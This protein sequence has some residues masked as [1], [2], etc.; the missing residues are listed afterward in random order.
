MKGKQ[1]KRILLRL[2]GAGALIVAIA[3]LGE[4]GVRPAHADPGAVLF[5]NPGVCVALTAAAPAPG[6]AI[7]ELGLGYD[8]GLG[9]TQLMGAANELGNNDDRIQSSDFAS[10]ATF[11][12][13]QLHQE[14]GSFH[15]TM[16]RL[17]VIAF[18]RSQGPVT[19]H[20]TSG[21]FE[22][23][24]T[25]IWVC[26]GNSA[27]KNPDTDCSP[28]PI[29]SS[30]NP[31]FR[32]DGVVVAYLSCSLVTCPTRGQFSLT[33]EQDGI[34]FPTTFTVVGEPINVTFF[35]LEKGIQAG[36]P[37]NGTLDASTASKACP[38]SATLPFIQKALGEA[39]K[40]VIVARAVDIDGTAIAG[41]WINWTVD[42]AQHV[43]ARVSFDS[44]GILAQPE[45]P[46]LNLGGFGYGA[47]NILC[48][49]AGAVA[50][51]ITVTAR[52][53]RVIQGL[54]GDPY[55]S[56]GVDP[57]NL[58]S[59][60]LA[61]GNVTFTVNAI[62][63]KMVLTA[64][65]AQIPCDGN[66]TSSV[67]AAL[68]DAAGNPAI[69][70]TAVHFDAQ[71]LGTANPID[72]T[73]NDKGIATSTIAPLAGDVR[74]VPVTVSVKV[75]GVLQPDMTQS[76]MVQC[77]G[78]G[79]PSTA[80]SAPGAPAGGPAPSAPSGGSAAGTSAVQGAVAPNLPR[81]GAAEGSGMSGGL[82]WALIAAAA[83][84]ASVAGVGGVVA[85]RR[86]R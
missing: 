54:Y 55:A 80:P 65:P 60:N 3:G 74:G 32:P 50:G 2:A 23:S 79:A 77:T 30:S 56:H 1:M 86:T 38:F 40:T 10:A 45:T 62:P 11:S 57:T 85:R 4:V 75:G 39:E 17:A 27:K 31:P 71:V 6:C 83:T 82:S 49:H 8:L 69:S 22:E 59:A 29:A 76:I 70:G 34:V 73:T 19:F 53:S 51:T 25:S 63:S 46:T 35:T 66:A 81:S 47:P 14:D 13:G 26:D 67:S 24:G 16:S 44:E 7:N 43:P 9:D 61:Y 52:L 41:A 15:P 18:V 37:V 58:K 42:D 28:N 36:V 68:T 84:L 64:A 20:T 72:A 21:F 48:A 78:S 12:G 33:V 5:V